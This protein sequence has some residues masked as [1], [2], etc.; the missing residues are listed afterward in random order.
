MVF[1]LQVL[2]GIT[3]DELYILDEFEDI[4]YERENVQV[5]LT[6]SHFRQIIS[7]IV[8]NSIQ[9]LESSF[10]PQDSSEKLQ[11]K[12]YVWAKKDDPDLYATWEFEVTCLNL[13][14]QTIWSS[15]SSLV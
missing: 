8:R 2:F 3:D 1:V 4:E 11:T 6:V 15:A 5:L 14:A 10:I 9:I 12:T 13:S 7:S